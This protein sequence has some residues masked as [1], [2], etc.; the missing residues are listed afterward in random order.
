MP[1]IPTLDAP[2]I[3]PAAPGRQYQQ[4]DANPAAFG[5]QVGAALQGLGGAVGQAGNVL[6]EHALRFQA[7]QNETEV[8]DIYAKKF[9]PAVR[10]ALFGENGYYRLQGKAA[11]DGVQGVT[12]TL[13]KLRDDTLAGLSNPA[14]HRAFNAM[15]TRRFQGELD[16]VARHAAQQNLIYR[17]QASTAL[18]NDFLQQAAAY[19]NNDR[20]FAQS[21]TGGLEEIKA[22][23]MSSGLPPEVIQQ[24]A[25][26]FL[27]KAWAARIE[28]MAI[29]DPTGALTMMR[30]HATDIDGITMLRLEEK[31][32]PK[33]RAA[34]A[35]ALVDGLWSGGAARGADGGWER[36]KAAESGGRQFA[37][38]GSPLVSPKGAVGVS[39]ILPGTAEETARKN[40]IP[41]DPQRLRTDA[42]YNERLGQL[43]HREMMTR[44]D[45]MPVLA[46]AAYN[47]G[48]G[49]VD[50]W[51]AKYGDPR[52]G[53][54]TPE[55]WAGKI[56]FAE[57]RA[58][59]TK[60]GAA[61][62]FRPPMAGPD[63]T[64]QFP[65]ESRLA[66]RI[67]AATKDDPEL[68]HA[69]LA[70]L[71]E[72][73]STWNMVNA[74]ERSDIQKQFGD[75]EQALL[76]GKDDVAIPADRIRAVFPPS[77]ALDMIG[78]LE[79]AKMAGQ[80]MRSVRFGTPEELA[81]ARADL[82]EGTGTLSTM[83]RLRGG[84]VRTEGADGSAETPEQFGLRKRVL[85]AFDQQL[86]ARQD[87]LEK[88][89]AGY[90]MASP[91]V[92]AAIAA[93]PNDPGTVARAVLAAQGQLGVPEDRR[94]VLPAGQVQQIVRKFSTLDPATGDA[95]LV[96]DQMAKQYGDLWPQV[97]G[98]L[99]QVG[100]MPPQYQALAWMDR[101]DQVPAR[102]DLQRAM[103]TVATK[104]LDAL[105]T[106]AGHDNVMTI[107]KAL[108]G[109]IAEFAETARHDRGGADLIATVRGSVQILAYQYA[110]LGDSPGKAVE[111]A[112]EGVV[113]AKYDMDGTMRVP[114][115]M[116]PQVR[117][118]TR[119]LQADLTADK[120]APNP[121]GNEG[122]TVERRREIMLD[123]AKNG[124]W[125]P[126]ARDD[127]L[128]LMGQLRTSPA[129]RPVLGAN[130]QPIE[131]KFADVPSM[132]PPDTS[133]RGTGMPARDIGEAGRNA[134]RMRG[135]VAP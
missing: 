95:T 134:A 90:V 50:E 19:Y 6:A 62:A 89:P 120:L 82:A 51:I 112:Y 73:V 128:V 117:Q 86:M 22:H 100:K 25:Q 14:Q 101:P 104:G 79:V 116:L 133:P 1:Q 54:I 74:T 123:A 55:E 81:A 43:Y 38:D 15:A 105:K 29:D 77:T 127:G 106:A 78:K 110:M 71:R 45:G 9:S 12:D 102:A 135:A 27:S 37:A 97:W 28:R 8:N 94:H 2:Q 67:I 119:T 4:I 99:V 115:G 18:T 92:Q 83:L 34:V 132:I 39:Q 56:P 10:D 96:L 63:G 20:Q 42:A 61:G 36:I 13:Q 31:L 3:A 53:D 121:P 49:R 70:R 26:Q 44:Y 91:A 7:I 21:V 11:V 88:D 76:A 113:G 32:K 107:D 40:G 80:L 16:G 64:V 122:L 47:A 129:L 46:D 85:A 87:A 93:N 17:A 68:Q 114:K 33:S 124:S 98:D 66:Q 57:T 58:Y 5:S 52:K 72:R 125:V 30:A 111:R 126:N 24:Q 41:F 60:T 84:Q 48:P 103:V 108:D 35:D 59:V 109:R 130:G 65:D 23:G 131:I 69:A 75:A 118:A